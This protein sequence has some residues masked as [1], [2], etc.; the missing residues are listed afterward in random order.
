M[1]ARPAGP[2]LG[3]RRGALRAGAPG[4]RARRPQ[5]TPVPTDPPLDFLLQPELGVRLPRSSREGSATNSAVRAGRPREPAAGARPGSAGDLPRAGGAGD[6]GPCPGNEAVCPCR[7]QA[8]LYGDAEKP[9][10]T[11]ARAAAPGVAE[12][13]PTCTCDKKPC[14]C[15]KADVNYAF[16]HSTGNGAPGARCF[17][18][19][20][21]RNPAVRWGNRLR[22]RC[23]EAGGPGDAWRGAAGL[24]AL[25]PGPA[26][27][28][29]LK[30]QKIPQRKTQS[31][32]IPRTGARSFFFLRSTNSADLS[33]KTR[34]C[35]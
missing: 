8:L 5:P 35:N 32:K 1:T 13:R 24:C 18:K 29:S 14:G 2:G 28:K 7:C 19:T 34:R 30:Q 11:G 22:W 31:S 3:Q 9:V 17:S 16:L 21:E 33:L 15:Q 25:S 12:P 27:R 23:A 6:G 4:E 10:E 26:G 20:S